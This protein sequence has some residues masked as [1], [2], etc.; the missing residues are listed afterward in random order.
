[1]NKIIKTILALFVFAAALMWAGISI[2]LAQMPVLWK[3]KIE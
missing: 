1:M 3:N 2:L